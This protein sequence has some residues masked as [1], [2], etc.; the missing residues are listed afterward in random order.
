LI[1][2]PKPGEKTSNRRNGFQTHG[3]KIKAR[4]RKTKAYRNENQ[5]LSLPPIETFQ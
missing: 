3:K 2:A 1:D 4:G 5:M